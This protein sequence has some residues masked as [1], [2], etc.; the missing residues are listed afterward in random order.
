MTDEQV[1]QIFK[2]LAA[3][4]GNKVLFSRDRY[5]VWQMVLHHAS[6]DEVQAAVIALLGEN[7]QFPP[8]VGEVN[9]AVLTARAGF[10][11]DWGKLWERVMIAAQRSTYYAD[12][13]A[14]KLPPAALAA[15]GGVVGLKELAACDPDK[16]A[17]VR[18]QFRQ[19]L[20]SKQVMDRGNANQENVQVLIDNLMTKRIGHVQEKE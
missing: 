5:K 2:V 15:V 8:T 14:K 17:I 19:R 6:Y 3:E 1:R 13:E 12:E 18:A 11:E 20:E 7:R 9:Q 4:F 10:K 16:I